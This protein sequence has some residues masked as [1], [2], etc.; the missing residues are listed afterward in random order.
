MQDK[1][2]FHKAYT[3]ANDILVSASTINKFPFDADALIREQTDIEF[4][5]YEKAAEYGVDVRTFG[6]E[7]AVLIEDD[8][9]YIIFYNDKE[10]IARQ[11]FSKLHEF[12]HYILKHDLNATGNLYDMQEIET[13]FFTAQILMPEQIMQEFVRRQKYISPKFLAGTFGVSE[14]AAEKRKKTFG[15]TNPYIRK[16]EERFFDD[17]ILFKYKRFIDSVAPEYDAFDMA[18]EYELQAERDRW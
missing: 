10:P 12:G 4:C 7:S 11:K 16:T 6:S 13:N 3:A 1:P 15:K 17:A 8:G 2:D 9:M 18:Y 5:S 14:E